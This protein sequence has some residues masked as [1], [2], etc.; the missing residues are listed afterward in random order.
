MNDADPEA[1]ARADL[2]F[3]IWNDEGLEAM[4]ERFW[5]PDI[6]WEESSEFPDAGVRRGRDEAVARMNERLA[7]LGHVQIEVLDARRIG[8]N[9]LIETIVSGEG[10]ASG[11]RVAQREYFVVTIEDGV[12][13]RF[14]E[15]LDRDAAIAAAESDA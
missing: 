2:V 4:A 8:R 9:T 11:A 5:H 10:S 13:T 6:V 14:R 15:F 3:G 1:R 7:L 12:T